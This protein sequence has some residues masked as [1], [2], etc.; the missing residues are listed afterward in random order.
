MHYTLQGKYQQEHIDTMFIP[1][2]YP[3]PRLQNI[4]LILLTTTAATTT[5]LMHFHKQKPFSPKTSVTLGNLST[6]LL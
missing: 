1:N 3:L 4:I 2:R 5:S 6:G